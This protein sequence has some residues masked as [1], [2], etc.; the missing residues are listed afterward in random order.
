MGRMD[1]STPFDSKQNP[2]RIRRETSI[3]RVNAR[4]SVIGSRKGRQI[5]GK[6][7]AAL[8]VATGILPV[9]RRSVIG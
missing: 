2:K 3:A 1:F 7:D 6:N 8:I 4:D 9:M 5:R